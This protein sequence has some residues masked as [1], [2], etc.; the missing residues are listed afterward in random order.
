MR[1]GGIPTALK[2]AALVALTIAAVLWPRPG[3]AQAEGVVVLAVGGVNTCVLSADGGVKCWGENTVGQVGDGTV[4]P[5]RL[6]PVDVVGLEGE[7]AAVTT[8]SRS[9]ALT[10]E[11]A[12]KCWGANS[13]GQLGDGTTTNR[14]TPVDVCQ[15]YDQVAGEC[16]EL[17]SGVAAIAVGSS[18]HTCALTS[19]GGVKCWGRNEYGQLGDGTLGDDDPE[20]LDNIRL[21][22]VD[23]CQDYDEV[24]EECTELLSGVAAVAAGGNY[25]CAVMAD[26]TA[27]CWGV[28]VAGKLGDGAGGGDLLDPSILPTPVDVCQEYDEAAERCTEL[29]TGVAAIAPASLH[30]CA[31]T[32]VGGIKCWGGSFA[33]RLGDGLVCGAELPFHCLTP[34]DV[35]GLESGAAAVT[36]GGSYTC[37]L[38]TAGG[39]KCW[40]WNLNHGSIGDGRRCGLVCPT[41]VDVCADAACTGALSGVTAIGAGSRH[42][43]ALTTAGTVKCW[44]W[45]NFGQ[46]GDGTRTDRS[47]PVDVAGLEPKAAPTPTATQ[48]PAVPAGTPTATE[49]APSPPAPSPTELISVVLPVMLPQTGTA[50]P[51]GAGAAPWMAGALAGAGAMAVGYAARR[52]R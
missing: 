38:T 41:P 4:S 1:H 26:S 35:V 5:G 42:T 44:G 23:V 29:L 27:R 46:L 12:L 36:A 14:S 30:T 11:G 25:T 17:L 34:V 2:L 16:R 43:C 49:A 7:V 24:A 9:C 13:Y 18:L 47:T 37:A 52:I 6:T 28:N 45:N 20:T 3:P 39:V 32:T 31:L 48:T 50:G 21:T 19:A 51:S 8:G 15:D 22:P 33:G 10:T 40:G